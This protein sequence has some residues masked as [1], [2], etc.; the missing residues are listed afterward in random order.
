M[1][2]P[3]TSP[4]RDLH[5]LRHRTGSTH[6]GEY[7]D[8]CDC[9]TDPEDEQSTD[10]DAKPGSH[11]IS[12]KASAIVK[13]EP[14]ETSE[15]DGNSVVSIESMSKD[16]GMAYSLLRSLLKQPRIEQY[17]G[18]S[19]DS[20]KRCEEDILDLAHDAAIKSEPV[21]SGYEDCDGDSLDTTA[22]DKHN[23]SHDGV[24]GNCN[25]IPANKMSADGDGI[26]LNSSEVIELRAEVKRLKNG[27]SQQITKNRQQEVELL[28]SQR[29]VLHLKSA[30][31]TQEVTIAELSQDFDNLHQQFSAL[32]HKF[33]QALDH[34]D[35]EHNP[36]TKKKA[37]Y[38]AA[39]NGNNS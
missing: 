11:V 8:C 14:Q 2:Y 25:E 33:K 26:S 37:R 32:K 27:V 12:D 19:C 21:S 18:K 16:S 31:C 30:L 9:V 38:R 4:A 29:E 7:C 35:K 28:L 1:A 6:H 15:A 13:S 36:P 22:G 17:N 3:H 23:D 10:S 5:K 34:L 20:E 24:V 39:I